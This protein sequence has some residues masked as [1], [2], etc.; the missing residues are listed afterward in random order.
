M[1]AGAGIGKSTEQGSRDVLSGTR[2]YKV[3]QAGFSKP[4]RR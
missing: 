2:I 1:L 4:Q 3:L